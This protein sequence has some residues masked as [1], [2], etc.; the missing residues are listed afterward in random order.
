MKQICMLINARDVIARIRPEI[1]GHFAEHLGRCVYGGIYVGEDSAI[2]HVNG[3]RTDVVEAFRNIRVPTIRWPGGCFAEEYHWK[4]GVGPKDKRRRMVNINWGGVVE[5]NSFGTHEYMELCRQVG[6]KPYINGNVGSGT[7]QEMAEWVEY[8]TAEGTPMAEWRRANGQSD[9]WKLE[10][11]GVGNENWGCGGEMTAETYAAHFRRFGAF[12]RDHNG[13]RLCRIA[14]GPSSADYGWMETIMK[15]LSR[16]WGGYPLAGGVDLHYYTMP[17][18]PQ[19][20]SATDFDDK[21]HYA[22]MESAAFV[23]EL[24]TRHTEI[25]NRYDPENRVG[26]VIGEWGCWHQVEPGTNPGF[27]YQQNAMRDALVAA[28]HLNAFNR[29]SRRVMM[30]NLAQTVN[31]LQAV[32]L[33]DGDRLVKTP[34][35]HVF[36]LFKAHQEGTAVYC[37]TDSE[38]AAEGCRADMVSSSA[39]VLDGVMTITLSNCSLTETVEIA[40]DVCHFSASQVRARIL[41]ADT[42][43]FNDFDHPEDVVIRPHTAEYARG[44]LCVTLPPCS[45]AE[46]T[47]S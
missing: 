23:D 26:L 38:K 28:I 47:L 29:H 14:C 19:M 6:C 3:I 5:D 30:A 12:C 40:C 18:H 4:D 27:L 25:M 35:Y 45:V 17:I 1:Y 36:D 2:P 7:V 46:V 9:P 22:T 13:N 10:F 32:L 24:L 41:T 11:L 21:L 33:T 42:H 44:R 20:D 34:T 16:G 37:Y 39:S 8:M 43:A 31:V 15:S